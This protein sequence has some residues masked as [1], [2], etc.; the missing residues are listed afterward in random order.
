V[1]DQRRDDAPVS[2]TPPAKG[3]PTRTH[4]VREKLFGTRTRKIISAVLGTPIVAGVVVGLILAVIVPWLQSHP[5]P[6]STIIT[7][8]IHYEPWNVTNPAG[9]SLT[10]VKVART[11]TGHC[12][13]RSVVTNRPDA[14]RCVEPLKGGRGSLFDPCIASP[15]QLP[16]HATRVVCPYPS[17]NFV[18]V[19]RLTRPLTHLLH[20]PRKAL[21]PTTIWYLVL[22]NGQKCEAAGGTVARIISHFKLYYYCPGNRFSIYNYPNRKGKTWTIFGQQSDSPNITTVAIARAYY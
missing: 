22:A 2:D 18:T 5:S 10:N 3:A 12:W 4:R 19:I 14:Y 1:N 13:E 16:A 8:V 20:F 7:Q 15:Y 11:L 9:T 6:K 21:P 17:P